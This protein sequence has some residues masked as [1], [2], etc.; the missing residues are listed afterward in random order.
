[1]FGLSTVSD[2]GVVENSMTTESKLTPRGSVILGLACAAMS[3]LPILGGLGVIDL[4]L[5]PGTP[6]W[7]GVGA[8][9]VFLLAGLTLIVDGASGAIGPDGQLTP[10]APAWVHVFQS[11]MG[12][13]I[14][15]MMGAIASWIAFGPGERHFS[16]ISLPFAWWHPTSGDSAGRWAF[17]I[18]A[19][20]IWC[21][22]AGV[23]VVGIRRL[24]V[25]AR[26]LASRRVER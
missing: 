7:V 25:R 6:R 4:K 9:A 24:I 5:T 21:I 26:L 14:V 12:L 18:A 19:V 10:E 16:T 20:L 22:I 15:G 8:G 13:G 1:L 3:A 2:A 23:I 11:L 17:G